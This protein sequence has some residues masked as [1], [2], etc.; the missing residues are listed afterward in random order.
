VERELL[1]LGL[2][3]AAVWLAPSLDDWE[4]PASFSFSFLFALDVDSTKLGCGF[5]VVGAGGI[6]PRRRGGLASCSSQNMPSSSSSAAGG[7]AAGAGAGFA[8]LDVLLF[9]T[10]WLWLFAARG[11][12]AAGLATAMGRAAAL[13]ER[14]ACSQ[15]GATLGVDLAPVPAGTGRFCEAE[16]DTSAPVVALA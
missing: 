8:T 12:K 5:A 14:D 7:P 2:A 4:G 11:G 9:P 13:E 16:A 10:L 15:T 6:G 3:M 1:L